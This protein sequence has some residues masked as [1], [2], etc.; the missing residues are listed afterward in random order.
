MSDYYFL[1]RHNVRTYRSEGV[2]QVIKGRGEAE[3][4]LKKWEESQSSADHRE[5]W[6]YFYEQANLK[7]PIEPAEATKLRQTHLDDRES[8]ASTE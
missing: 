3:K 4:A 1:V 5:G 6:R 8:K 7:S 2:V